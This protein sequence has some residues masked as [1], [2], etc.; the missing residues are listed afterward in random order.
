MIYY[1]EVSFLTTFPQYIDFKVEKITLSFEPSNDEDVLTKDYLDTKL[2]KIGGHLSL[3][4][5]DYIDFKLRNDK[6]SAELLTEKVVK[7]SFQMLYEKGLI[8]KYDNVDETFK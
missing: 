4:E 5:N 7:T 6:Q 2:S 8:D 1:G 3:I